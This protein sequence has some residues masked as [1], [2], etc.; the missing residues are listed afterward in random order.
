MRALSKDRIAIVVFS[1]TA[2]VL[3]HVAAHDWTLWPLVVLL[4][5]VATFGRESDKQ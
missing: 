1:T 2:G 3:A 5:V 4:L